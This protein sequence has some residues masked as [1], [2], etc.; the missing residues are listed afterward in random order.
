MNL[1]KHT[2]CFPVQN[3]KSVVIMVTD[4]VLCEVGTEFMSL[5][6]TSFFSC[7]CTEVGTKHIVTSFTWRGRWSLDMS[8]EASTWCQWD[9]RSSGVLRSVDWYLV[10][11]TLGKTCRS[12]WPLKIGSI[13][14]TERSATT[15]L[16][17]VAPRKGQG[18]SSLNT[19]LW[20][21]KGSD[22]FMLGWA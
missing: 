17:C 10:A 5:K 1:A 2:I 16:H 7:K 8:L 6:W 12:S 9:L 11:D 22:Y 4:C 21:I 14:T 19:R 18:I 15:N 13:D 20:I 3:W